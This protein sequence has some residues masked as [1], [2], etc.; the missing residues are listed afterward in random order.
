MTDDR[1][2]QD[3]TSPHT[4]ITGYTLEA[5]NWYDGA[6]LADYA[7]NT[8]STLLVEGEAAGGGIYTDNADGTYSFD[9]VTTVKAV[10]IA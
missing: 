1:L 6:V 7:A 5:H 10:L 3:T 4:A 9:V 8:Y 2:L